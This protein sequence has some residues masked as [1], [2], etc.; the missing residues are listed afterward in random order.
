MKTKIK[1][2]K[3]TTYIIDDESE[4]KLIRF[5]LDYCWHRATKHKT[6]VSGLDKGINKMRK[7]FEK[8]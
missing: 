7:E 5:C 4:L 1:L 3:K 2:I 8:N 6:P